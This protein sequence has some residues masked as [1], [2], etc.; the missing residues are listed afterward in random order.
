MRELQFYL[1]VN[2]RNN[3]EFLSRFS[4][5][6]SLC[7]PHIET[8]TL[9]GYL[10]NLNFDNLINLKNLAL[11]GYLMDDFNFDIFKNISNQLEEI[12]LMSY[13]LN[14]KFFA[15]LFNGYNF[16]YL[17]GLSL[18][19]TKISKFEKKSFD[20]FPMLQTLNLLNNRELRKI[21]H[22]AFSN[23]KHLLT[24]NLMYNCIN[25]I[26]KSHFSSLT[27]L[28]I[29]FLGGNPL[30]NI[31]KYVFS[32]LKSLRYLSLNNNQL[33]TIDP[34]SFTG[35]NSLEF[36]SLINNTLTN[37]DFGIL[38]KIGRIKEI[39]LSGNPIINKDITSYSLANGEKVLFKYT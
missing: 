2:S 17:R 8:L 28:E 4:S 29:L 32:D 39:D 38:D 33:T 1:K 3:F 36:L 9:H 25:S 35:L 37:F 10:S 18:A 27:K 23:L 19:S 26:E 5:E 31:K 21:D 15:Q 34:I 12:V 16:P 13:N 20:R 7:L 6:L 30:G 24:L 11:T 22:D 14:D